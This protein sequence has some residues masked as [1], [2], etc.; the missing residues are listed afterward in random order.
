MVNALMVLCVMTSFDSMSDKL[1]D[2]LEKLAWTRREDCV[3]LSLNWIE[4]GYVHFKHNRR[5]TVDRIL[6]RLKNHSVYS[7]GRY[8]QWDYLSMEDS[9]LS[10]IKVVKEFDK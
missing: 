5:E 1:F 10:G 6:D 8:G 7:I 3:A 4:C 2:V 9:I